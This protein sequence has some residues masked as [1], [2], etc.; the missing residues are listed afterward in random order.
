MRPRHGFVACFAVFVLAAGGASSAGRDLR[1]IE[2]SQHDDF[3]AAK[4]LMAAG[5]GV[6]ARSG[7]G[8]T[9]LHWAA[10]NGDVALAELLIRKG[11]K[12]NAAT[13]LAVTPLWVAASNSNTAMIE[14]LL[15]AGADPNIAPPT[16]HTALMM[17]ARQGNAQA[18]KALL[19]HG[20]DPN[21]REA[22]EG[23][24]ALM[25]AA[26][27]RHAD[28]V[29]L[30]LA[31]H[32][33]VRA[34]AKSWTQRMVLCCQLYG[35]DHENEAMVP[36]GG[37][38]PLLFTAQSGD[39]DTAKLLLAAGADVNDKAPDGESAVVIAAHMGQ[40]D[41]GAFLLGAGADANA[42]GAGYSALHIAAARGDVVLAQAL[43]AHGADPNA[44]ATKGTPTKRVRSGHEVDQRLAGATPFI[45]AAGSGQLE[46]MKLLVAKGADPSIRTQDG[47]TAL[48]V[49]AGESTTEGPDLHDAQ[50]AQAIRL[51]VQLGTPVNQTLPPE[52]DTAL[53]VAATWRRDLV[54]QALVDS[55]ADLNARNLAGQT[56]LTAAL[57]PPGTQKG[58]VAS[59]DYEALL[60]HTQTAELLRKLGAKT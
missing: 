6:N 44:R 47:R 20:A 50:A 9:A 26:A 46:V 55:G 21:A 23:Q 3:A 48:M 25:W 53:H 30:L 1:L 22:A 32:A 10:Q 27:A 7:D 56:P 41:V 36:V 16:G 58:T 13:D 38:T 14:R 12:V 51:A 59:D 34:R 54:V 2:A 4:A 60:H 42:S 43:L 49:L 57:T 35:G 11:A 18:V 28:V 5:V 52:G 19:E 8:S 33:D 45:L 17:A 39:V 37:Y 31:A 29:R 15:Q 24:T 40:S